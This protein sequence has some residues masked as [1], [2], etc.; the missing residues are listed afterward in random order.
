[1]LHIS[2]HIHWETRFTL[3]CHVRTYGGNKKLH[4]NQIVSHM[5]ELWKQKGYM[6]IYVHAKS[7]LC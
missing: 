5:V 3:A 2:C 6:L 7:K 4:T 1:M